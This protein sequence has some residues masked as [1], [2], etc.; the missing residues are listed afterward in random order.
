[1]D[2]AGAWRASHLHK[3][4]EGRSGVVIHTQAGDIPFRI[5]RH[6][7]RWRPGARRPQVR[8]DKAPVAEAAM[9]AALDPDFK[10]QFEVRGLSAFPDDVGGPGA[11]LGRVLRGDRALL[12]PPHLGI[13]VPAVQRP[14]VEDLGRADAERLG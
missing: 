3:A 1:A 8:I 11:M 12:Y 10:L 14:P 4:R 7:H 9:D 5:G 2:L 6:R 13:A